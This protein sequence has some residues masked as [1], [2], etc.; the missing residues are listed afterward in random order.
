MT[1]RLAILAV[2]GLDWSLLQQFIDA[3]RM[4]FCAQLLDAG[5]SGE[6]NMP[7]PHAA[8][9]CWSTVATGTLAD[10]HGVLTDL[11]IRPDG[12]TLGVPGAEALHSPAIWQ[13]VAQAG[14]VAKTAGWPASVPALYPASPDPALPI[15]TCHVSAG[16]ERA[17]QSSES[18][19][20]LAPD[21]VYP[22]ALRDVVDD[23]RV[24]PDD[25]D[26]ATA[27]PLL[28][29]P[30]IGQADP[31]LRPA[32]CL[33]ARF[34]SMHN[35]GVHW[36]GEPDWSLLALRFDGLPDWAQTLRTLAPEI[37]VSEGLAPWY[38]Y[39]DMMVGRYMAV[40]G[41]GVHL[42]LLSNGA[43][44]TPAP[45]Q[46]GP[47]ELFKPMARG[48][49]ILAGPR[50]KPDSLLPPNASA[51]DIAPTAL[52]LLGLEVSPWLDGIDL[53]AASS[54]G[55]RAG[56]PAVR[57]STGATVAP[58]RLLEQAQT[59]TR[60][61][62]WL[63]SQAC[64]Q[65]DLGPL[66]AMVHKVRVESLVAW[67]GVRRLRGC[68]DDAIEALG[69]VL[70]L[71]PEHLSARLLLG[72]LLLETDRVQACRALVDGLPAAGQ[73][74]FSPDVVAGLI[75]YSAKEWP[76]AEAHFH[77]L[78]NAGKAPINAPGWL[79]W[80]LLMQSRWLDA[81]HWFGVALTWPGE[82]GRALEGLGLALDAQGRAGEAAE[83]FSN[84]VGEQ[85]ANARLHMLRAGALERA[86]DV[87][88][89]QAAFWR[90]LNL[91]PTLTTAYERLAHLTRLTRDESR[92]V[93]AD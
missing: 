82:H 80:T 36:A 76:V 63:A 27:V 35:L 22:A 89:A 23:A 88:R 8:A 34:A 79:G 31:L 26:P 67:A 62:D 5:A 37:P 46:S 18:C 38:R 53:L 71:V 28:S 87:E 78:A 15:G 32:R 90:A 40:L 73:R 49:V 86:G 54:A 14:R 29:H 50:I 64:G 68:N 43:L 65:V 48:G 10:R 92:T 4:P 93:M 33:L 57:Q 52:R 60:A 11:C 20:P 51:L 74:V 25:I 91:D 47:I 24:H 84:A 7:A 56:S 42:M 85:P 39:L 1:E 75:A 66:H 30:R 17:E 70:T 44:L 16:F 45:D 19:W 9:A 58:H 59:D 83:Y 61:L 3:G 69:H 72:Q 13:R 55:H 2:D 41:R 12:L 81:Q 77:R 6:L 21:A